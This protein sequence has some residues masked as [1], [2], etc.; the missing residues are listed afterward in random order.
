MRGTFQRASRIASE[1]WAAVALFIFVYIV[2]GAVD[3]YVLEGQPVT[4]VLQWFWL[5]VSTLMAKPLVQLA[6]VPLA[7]WMFYKGVRQVELKEEQETAR[8]EEAAKDEAAA[9]AKVLQDVR[10]MFASEF[11]DLRAKLRR[12]VS[13]S[14]ALASAYM[15]HLMHDPADAEYKKFSAKLGEYREAIDELARPDARLYRSADLMKYYDLAQEAT[16][17]LM[18]T[19]ALLSVE[20]AP[21]EIERG[22]DS[23]FDGVTDEIDLEGKARFVGAH[24]RNLS[25]LEKADQQI[26]RPAMQKVERDVRNRLE[27]MSDF[28]RHPAND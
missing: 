15:L 6:L 19:A 11:E 16:L 25:R 5:T 20:L 24:R 17:N 14:G 12:N 10:E 2:V 26:V 28:L 3:R 27:A 4:D 18:D 23:F 1:P 7:M 9:R 22:D 13:F 21:P 8:R